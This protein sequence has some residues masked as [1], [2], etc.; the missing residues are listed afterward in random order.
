VDLS[1]RQ[2]VRDVL[3]DPPG[4]RHDPWGSSTPL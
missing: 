2:Q 4:S 1:T 3:S